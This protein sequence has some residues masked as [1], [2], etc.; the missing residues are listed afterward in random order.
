MT[1]I[2]SAWPIGAFA[3]EKGK[4]IEKIIF[5]PNPEEIAEKLKKFNSDEEFPELNNITDKLKRRKL[6]F[7]IEKNSKFLSENFRKLAI[8]EKFVKNQAELNKLMVQLQIEK[9]KAK[10]CG[11][12]SYEKLKA[13][14]QGE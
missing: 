14:A 13:F 7:I 6:K 1:V 10:I 8:K 4:I 5:K 2:V 11:N 3:I 12:T 9:T